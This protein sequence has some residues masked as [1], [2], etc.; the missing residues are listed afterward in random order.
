MAKEGSK[1]SSWWAPPHLLKGLSKFLLPYEG[2]RILSTD[3]DEEHIKAFADG[4]KDINLTCS[5]CGGN[6]F[7]VRVLIEAEAVIDSTLKPANITEL[8]PSKVHVVNLLECAECRC[9]VYVQHKQ[10][11]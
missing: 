4:A 10:I 7:K 9:D 6:K 3:H 5:V 8:D 2:I 11:C 1:L